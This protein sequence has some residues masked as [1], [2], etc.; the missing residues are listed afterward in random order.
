[1][2]IQMTVDK[3]K[4]K[5]LPPPDPGWKV[6]RL[7]GFKPK[8]NSKKDG[9]NFN[10]VLEIE[11]CPPDKNKFVFNSLSNKLDAF[12]LDFCHGF[13]F[14]LEVGG[15]LPGGFEGEPNDPKTWQYKGPL[16]GKTFEAECFTSTY[17]NRDSLKIK[18]IRCKVVGCKERHNTN[19]N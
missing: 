15:A 11:N 13:G 4:I 14:E 6:L 5:I 1:M 9:V 16:M 8:T 19:W 3:E 12:L 17:N 18:Q 7:T 10:P 2:P